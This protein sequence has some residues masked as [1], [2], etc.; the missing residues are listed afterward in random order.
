LSCPPFPQSTKR[1]HFNCP[2][3]VQS[4]SVA[5]AGFLKMLLHLCSCLSSLSFREKSCAVRPHSPARIVE[6]RL[7]QS[8]HPPPANSDSNQESA[9]LAS[10]PAAIPSTSFSTGISAAAAAHLLHVQ[11]AIHPTTRH[12]TVT[13]IIS[14]LDF[15]LPKK[16]I[17]E[18]HERLNASNTSTACPFYQTLICPAP[19]PVFLCAIARASTG[20]HLPCLSGSP[21]CSRQPALA[22]TP[23]QNKESLAPT[24]L[25][26]LFHRLPL[27][28]TPEPLHR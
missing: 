25:I 13:P 4:L 28:R 1:R 5:S 11:P 14:L 21:P 17:Q 9:C 22:P 3:L 6:N 27:A 15:H 19:A 16:F 23:C 20:S 12:T 10:A 26:V 8:A 2:P 7:H 18:I 24:P